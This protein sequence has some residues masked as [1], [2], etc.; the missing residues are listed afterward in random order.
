MEAKMGMKSNA[1][2]DRQ[3]RGEAGDKREGEHVTLRGVGGAG[4]VSDKV[5]RKRKGR[6]N[7]PTCN[8]QYT[9]TFLLVYAR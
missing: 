2:E 7:L 3:G 1:E 9:S 4:R 6:L 5:C 8:R